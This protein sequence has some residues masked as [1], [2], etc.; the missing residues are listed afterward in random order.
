M[1]RLPTCP[2][3]HKAVT[4][5]SGSERSYAPFCGERCQQVDLVRWFDGRYAIVEDLEVSDENEFVE[6]Q[7]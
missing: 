1:V 5:P 7:E 4:R 6:E 3:C 2:I